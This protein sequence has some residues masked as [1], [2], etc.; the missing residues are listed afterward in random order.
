MYAGIQSSIWSNRFRT[1][2]LI[3]LFPIILFIAIY[4]VFL[5]L[6]SP[7]PTQETIYT[8]YILGPILFIWLLISF[9]FHKQILFKF[10]GAREVTRKEDPEIYNIVENLCI[11]RG[12][13]TPNIG[14]IEDKGMNAF[15]VGRDPKN[16]WI[17]FTRGLIQNLNRKEIEAVA[18]HELSH[19]INKDNL[20]MTVIVIFIG[21]VSTIGYILFRSLVF[22]RRGDARAK[23]VLFFIGLALVI[24]GSIVYPIM[25]FAVSRKREYLADAG[26]VELT[27]DNYAMISALEKI[28]GKPNV[29]SL[30]DENISNMCIEDP[31]QKQKIGGVRS[32]LHKLFSTHPTVEDR[33]K[34]LKSY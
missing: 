17:V 27:K 21:A 31:L 20:I 34:A 5:L 29:A 26:A 2:V 22:S 16:S 19:I 18:A 7:E 28:S 4:M 13:P 3:I 33:I 6:G 15:A 8:F 14:I 11:S 30:E 1:I 32:S 24:I 10:S 9:W 23:A 25:K 12:L